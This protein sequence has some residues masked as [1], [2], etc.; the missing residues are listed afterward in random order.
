MVEFDLHVATQETRNLDFERELLLMG[1]TSDPLLEPRVMFPKGEY[2]LLGT[3]MTKKY[4]HLDEVQRDMAIALE[5]M[6]QW[7]Q[8]GYLHGEA[9]SADITLISKSSLSLKPWPV[10]KFN[11]MPNAADKK[12][13]IH[14]AIPEDNLPASLEDVLHHSNSGFY[15]IALQKNREGKDRVFRAYTIQ[16]INSPTEGK[17]LF[18]VL[19]HW[20]ID[21]RAPYAEMKQET[22]IGMLRA[23]NPR[24]VPPT[25]KEVRYKS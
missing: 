13:D 20:L 21:S 1:F 10:E 17:R 18:Q 5:R 15:Y 4:S 9:T 14:I 12:W 8:I 2:P 24:I 7:G 3:H 19:S 16:G 6:K 11:A 23:G 25:I 22:Y